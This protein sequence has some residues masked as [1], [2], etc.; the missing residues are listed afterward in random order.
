MQGFHIIADLK[1]IN[2]S[3]INLDENILKNFLEKIILKNNLN[4]VWKNF[5]TFNKKDEIT[6][7]FLLAESHLSVHTWPE[8]WYISLD[9]FVCNLKNDNSQNAKNIFEEIL[10]F[11]ECKDFDKKVIKRK[12]K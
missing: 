12:A 7:V 1:G 8:F 6:G 9:I 11:F 3:K 5:H 10:E 4:I 2:F